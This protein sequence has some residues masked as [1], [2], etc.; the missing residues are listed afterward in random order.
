[1]LRSAAVNW[2][3]NPFGRQTTCHLK[4][5][6]GKRGAKAK[7]NLTLPLALAYWRLERERLRRWVPEVSWMRGRTENNFQWYVIHSF[8]LGL[9][10]IHFWYL[11]FSLRSQKKHAFSMSLRWI[12]FYCKL[13]IE[14]GIWNSHRH[15]RIS[16]L[17]CRI[18]RLY[19]EIHHVNLI[20][21]LYNM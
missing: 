21:Y 10:E 20:F 16:L 2:Y 1:M 9:Y 3:I 8:V 12:T 7:H 6:V 18:S 4:R 15:R 5:V 19:S 14:S 17:V 13:L 11:N